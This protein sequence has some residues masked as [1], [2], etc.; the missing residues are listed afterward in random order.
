MID[1]KQIPDEA[2]KATGLPKGMACRAIAAAL[3][4]W[5]GSKEEIERYIS[6]DGEP[7]TL[8]HLILPLPQEPER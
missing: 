5:P 3:N 6:F 2:W 7:I 1:P 4:A 8:H